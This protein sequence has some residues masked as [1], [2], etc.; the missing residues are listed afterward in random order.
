MTP[1]ALDA[2]Q[3]IIAAEGS[4]PASTRRRHG[5]SAPVRFER[6]DLQAGDDTVSLALHPHLTVI[7]GVQ[8]AERHAVVSELVGAL[9]ANGSDVHLDVVE[10]SGRR[11]AIDRPD[12]GPHRV[13]DLATSADVSREFQCAHGRIDVLRAHGI[14]A[15]T[16]VVALRLDRAGLDD[17]ARL[18]ASDEDEGRLHTA[19]RRALIGAVLTTIGALIIVADPIRNAPAVAVFLVATVFALLYVQRRT[20]PDGLTTELALALSWRLSASRH[21][22]DHGESF[23]L[24]LDEPFDGL[25]QRAKHALL[26]LT[27]QSAE[28]QQVIVLTDDRDVATWGRREAFTGALAL[29]EP[30]VRGA[31][32]S[33]SLGQ[34]V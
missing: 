21:L 28:D 22:G 12:H 31:T 8:P 1:E 16:A 29:I 7:A 2:R 27:L 23:P 11:L 24:I 20:G 30:A 26:D 10:D 32:S 15:D 18:Q 14:G 34:P 17:T 5:R 13:V 25:G 6:L 9:G 33:A 4:G 19:V 3:S